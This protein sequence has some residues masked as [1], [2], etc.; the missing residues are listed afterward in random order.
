MILSGRRSVCAVACLLV[1]ATLPMTKLLRI[2]CD[3]EGGETWHGLLNIRFFH[4]IIIRSRLYS[5]RF[6]VKSFGDNFAAHD[7]KGA[8]MNNCS[9]VCWNHPLQT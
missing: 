5:R 2:V 4:G 1:G 3:V 7:A 6:K 8:A 9:E